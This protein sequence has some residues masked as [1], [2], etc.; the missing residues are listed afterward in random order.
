MN[1]FFGAIISF[2]LSLDVGATIAI[3][4]LIIAAA[5]RFASDIDNAIPDSIDKGFWHKKLLKVPIL[6]DI[7]LFLSTFEIKKKALPKVAVKARAKK[8]VK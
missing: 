7:L 1:E 4:L 3:V 2:L 5:C 6:G 8:V